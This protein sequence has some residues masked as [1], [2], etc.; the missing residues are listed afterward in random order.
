MG[1]TG[2]RAAIYVRQSVREDQ[3]I[4]Q[5]TKDCK[6]RAKGEGWTVVGIYNDNATSATKDRGAGT[7]WARMLADI[8]AGKVDV[9]VC[10]AAARL[11]RRMVDVYEITKPKRDVRIVTLRDGIDTSTPG[12][13][14]MLTMLV[15]FA[16]AEI[17]EKEARAIPYRAARREAGHPTPGRVPY[18]YDWVPKMKRDGKGTRYAI[19]EDEAG[20]LRKMSADLLAGERLGAIARGLNDAGIFT[21]QG[22]PWHASTVRRVLLSPF[23]AALLPPPMPPGV[24]YKPELADLSKSRPGEWEAILDEDEVLAARHIILNSEKH[25]LTH[26][27]NTRPKWMLSTVGRCGSCGG[28]L[29][30]CKTKTTAKSER[31]Y[32]C[33]K[34]CFQRPAAPIEEYVTEAVLGVLSKPGLL[35]HSVDAAPDLGALRAEREALAG[36]YSEAEQLYREDRLS[37]T[38]FREISD[39][40]KDRAA[41]VETA[42]SDALQADPLA[43]ILDADD[44][45]GVW[46]SLSTGRQRV[47]LSALADW[48]AVHPVGKGKRVR[49]LEQTEGTVT[50]H[51]KKQRKVAKLDGSGVKIMPPSVPAEAQESIAA[52]LNQNHES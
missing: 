40:L 7:E 30:S 19:R 12:G 24:H 36:R 52:A 8:D 11:L 37:V 29:R 2:L 41:K 25:A 26:D 1:S 28:P 6:W 31:G 17:E 46:A 47:I 4:A 22:K 35:R 15:M 45:R 27:G 48:V 32:R 9:I 5:Q 20:V 39:D 21:R 49:T 44:I 42:I 18:G 23:P 13:K 50:V 51:W 14:I 43:E 10:V 33:T 34:G 3:G 16:E 38:V